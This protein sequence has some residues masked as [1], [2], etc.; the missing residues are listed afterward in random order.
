M[1]SLLNTQIHDYYRNRDLTQDIKRLADTYKSTERSHLLISIEVSPTI[2]IIFTILSLQLLEI[3]DIIFVSVK[4]GLISEYSL[5]R[6]EIE[7]HRIKKHC[8]EIYI[9][10]GESNSEFAFH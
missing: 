6:V 2:Q 5:A 7:L 4:G 3:S 10:L 8:S 9:K 1:L